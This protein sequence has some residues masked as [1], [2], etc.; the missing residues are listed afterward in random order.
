MVVENDVDHLAGGHRPLERVEEPD[1]LLMA[2]ALHAVAD[3]RAL[4]HVESGEQGGGAVALVIEGHGP[5][6]ATLD[7]QTRLGPVQGLDLALLVDREH[8]RVLGRIDVQADD[9]PE[10]GRELG[11]LGQLERF[12]PVGLQSMGGPDPLHRT[13]A[14]LCR[15]RHRPTAPVGRL[16][17]RFAQRQ[18][19]HPLH[20]RLGQRRLARRPALVAQEPVDALFHEPFLPAPHRRLGAAHLAHDGDRADAVGA[21]Q[22]DPRPFDMLLAAVAVRHDRLEPSTISGGNL[23]LDPRAHA[24]M[25]PHPPCR[26]DSYVCVVALA[27]RG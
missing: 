17:G 4:E 15:L 7:R 9:V 2:V 25:V 14:D 22:H 13:Q 1:E 27:C 10:L 24:A 3:H 11:V 26:W 6:L 23:D 5:G 12:D 16:A 19:D 21:Q 8:H 18:R 20:H